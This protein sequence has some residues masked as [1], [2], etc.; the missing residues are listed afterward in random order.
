VRR[1]RRSEALPPLRRFGQNFLVDAR[2]VARIR[3]ALSPAPGEALLEIGPGHG[4]LTAALLD[5]GLPVVAVE[6]DRGLAARLR[7][8]FAGRRLCLLEQDV[9]DLDFGTIPSRAGLPDDAP[10]VVAGN[11]PYNLS[12][13]IA[14][15][16]VE[17][18]A[19]VARAVLMFQREVADRLLA[20]PATKEYGPLTVLAGLAFR[21]ERVLDLSPGAFRPRP[22]VN[23]T[24]TCWTRREGGALAADVEP[25]LRRVLRAAFAR[26]RATL[27]V[28]V[29]AALGET[30]GASVLR[31]AEI[32]DGLRAERLRPEEFLRLAAAWPPVDLYSGARAPRGE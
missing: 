27:R 30:E 11:L 3:D 14:M 20:A 9:L 28:N 32:D 22:R 25:A 17:E 19:R 7:E 2:A 24:L 4:A 18:R 16:I 29:R 23:S 21:I 1:S 5:T 31:V 8:R 6:I 12:K 10:L 15:R 13:P 26:R